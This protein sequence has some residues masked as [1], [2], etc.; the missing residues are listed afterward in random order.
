LLNEIVTDN[1]VNHFPVYEPSEERIAQISERFSEENNPLN[2]HYDASK[3][4]RSKAAGFYA[5]STDEETR[6]QQMAELKAARTETETIRQELGAVDLKPGEVEGMQADTGMKS[7]AMEKRKRDIEE[8]RQ[9]IEAKRRK[10]KNNE[11][12]SK[13]T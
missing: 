3:E 13:A 11:L 12:P 8:R 1:P 6:K 9:L 2:M 5:F 4:V 10:L 7:R